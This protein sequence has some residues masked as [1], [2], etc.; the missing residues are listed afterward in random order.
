MVVA[1]AFIHLC[2]LRLQR[3]EWVGMGV[4]SPLG[5]TENR[6]GLGGAEGLG[7]REGVEDRGACWERKG[8][9]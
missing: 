8:R 9:R 6:V 4:W 2:F 1:M 3:D 5:C 7:R